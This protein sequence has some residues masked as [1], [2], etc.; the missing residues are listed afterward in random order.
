VIALSLCV[1][2]LL[3]PVSTTICVSS[4]THPSID[5]V[6]CR[7]A[8]KSMSTASS[9]TLSHWLKQAAAAAAAPVTDDG[10]EHEEEGSESCCGD[11]NTS[12]SSS[13]SDV[14][15][16]SSSLSDDIEGWL[17]AADPDS[18]STSPPN[19]GNEGCTLLLDDDGRR[20]SCSPL[21]C[22]IQGGV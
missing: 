22:S 6:S 8:H 15:A 21:L 10:V 1:C 7:S 3:C 18:A 4:S 20:V 11:I 9:P 5:F 19:A 14:L 16:L 2:C 12:P 13:N 17:E